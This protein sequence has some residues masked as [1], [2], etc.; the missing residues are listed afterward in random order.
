MRPSRLSHR[1]IL[2]SLGTNAAVGAALGVNDS[3]V[4]YWRSRGIPPVYWPKLARLAAE[5]GIP[6]TVEDLEASSPSRVIR[7]L[8]AA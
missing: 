2:I 6:L 7:R 5:Q 1:S 3:T 4:S 8:C